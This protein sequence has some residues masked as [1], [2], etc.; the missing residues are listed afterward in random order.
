MDPHDTSRT[1]AR[2]GHRAAKNRVTQ[3]SPDVRRAGRSAHADVNAAKNILRAGLGV[4]S[5]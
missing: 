1:H 2:R 5:L 4:Y 3:A